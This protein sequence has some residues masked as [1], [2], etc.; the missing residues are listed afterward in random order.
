VGSD[1]QLV[2]PVKVANGVTI[3]AGTTVTKDV[4]EDMLAISRAEQKTI[5]GWKRPKKK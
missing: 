4:A 2:A 5:K 3:A 1:T